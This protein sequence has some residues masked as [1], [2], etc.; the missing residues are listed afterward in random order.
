MHVKV[1][2][3][4]LFLHNRLCWIFLEHLH[5]MCNKTEN[6]NTTYKLITDK[7]MTWLKGKNGQNTSNHDWYS[8]CSAIL[9]WK[10]EVRVEVS[11]A[12]SQSVHYWADFCYIYAFQLLSQS[13]L[14]GC[15]QNYLIGW[16]KDKEKDGRLPPFSHCLF[17]FWRFYFF[18]V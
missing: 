10:V 7:M 8:L 2:I 18:Y 11:P 3:S 6:S 1:A 17:W 4:L 13:L 16:F 12:C 15:K 9:L 5:H 14:F